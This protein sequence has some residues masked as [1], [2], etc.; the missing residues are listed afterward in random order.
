[1]IRSMERDGPLATLRVAPRRCRSSS[2]L[3]TRNVRGA[4]A[5]LA[6]LVL[7][8]TWLVGGAAWFGREAQLRQLHHAADHVRHRLRV[9]V[10]RVR[11]L[12]PAGRRRHGGGEARRRRGRALQLHDGR[13]LRLAALRG[14]PG[15]AVVRPLAVQRRDRVPRRRAALLP[16]LLHVLGRSGVARCRVEP[17]SPT[18]RR[19]PS[20][21]SS[22]RSATKSPRAQASR[23]SISRRS[24]EQAHVGRVDRDARGHERARVL[25]GA[26]PGDRREQP[27]GRA[28]RPVEDHAR[29]ARGPRPGRRCAGGPR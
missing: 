15:A 9:P 21:S 29:R 7:G 23:R 6:A 10:Q 11:P 2:S 5:V 1:M 3:A 25:G 19:A 22:R 17:A 20:R 12:A 24:S 16:A 27:A 14:L 28:A 4:L 8:V 13:R 26:A 18:R